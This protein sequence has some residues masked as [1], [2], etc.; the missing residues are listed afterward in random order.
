[1]PGAARTALAFAGA[2]G[3]TRL[4]ARHRVDC[5]SGTGTWKATL[6]SRDGKRVE[7]APKCDTAM[8]EETVTLPGP[9]PF[10]LFVARTF[11][12]SRPCNF[13]FGAPPAPYELDSLAFE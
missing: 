5:A 7:L 3:A 2:T 13:P 4:R 9:G 1:M 12:P 11:F 8:L 6:V 10:A